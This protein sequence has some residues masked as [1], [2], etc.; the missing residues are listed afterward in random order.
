MAVIFKFDFQNLIFFRNS[1]G[2][3]PCAADLPSQSRYGE[4]RSFS[5]GARLADGAARSE[6]EII[7]GFQFPHHIQNRFPRNLDPV[8]L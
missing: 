3:H 5:E 2:R 8:A 7:A 1:I 4:A 6:F